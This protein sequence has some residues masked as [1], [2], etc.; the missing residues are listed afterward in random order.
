MNKLIWMIAL[1]VACGGKLQTLQ[2]D[3]GEGEEE[4]DVCTGPVID[5]IEIGVPQPVDIDVQI[6]ATITGQEGCDV[7]ATAVYYSP[8][9]S[10]EYQSTSLSLNPSTGEYRGNIPGS[11]VTSG[12]MRYYLYAVDTENNET[13]EPDDAD[14]N[15][16]EAWSF[17]VTLD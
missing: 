10:L 9:T 7:L 6:T 1:V 11:A 4:E 12:K 15:P 2:D 5:H 8:E 16:F 13:I 14:E 17:G 3:E